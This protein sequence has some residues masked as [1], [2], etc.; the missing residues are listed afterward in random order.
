MSFSDNLFQDAYFFQNSV[1][2]FNTFKSG[3]GGPY[4]P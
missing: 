4:G 3:Q 2:S 1:N